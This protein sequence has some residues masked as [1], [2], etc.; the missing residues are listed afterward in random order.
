MAAWLLAM[1]AIACASPAFGA[2]TLAIGYFD[3]TS[4]SADWQPLSKGLADMLITDLAATEG[5]VVVERERLQQV[6]DEIKLGGGKFIDPT[7]A[8]KLGKGLGA[9]H[10]LIGGFLV[11]Q[12]KLR[13]DARMVEVGSGKIGLVA[14]EIGSADDIFAIE[15]K[16][17]EKLRQAL[18]VAKKRGDGSATA[19]KVSADDVKTL[20]QGLDALDAGRIDEARR[21]LGA[22]AARKPDFS[23]VQR[24]LDQLSKKIKQ[25]LAQSKAAPEK[26]VALMS[27][28]EQGKLEAC[29]KL[30]MEVT[31]LLSA[32]VKATMRVQMPDGG[33][34]GE[35]G[36]LLAAFYAVTL[37][38]L[39]QPALQPPVCYGQQPAGTVI[40]M[41]LMSLQQLAQLQ[42]KCDP[43]RLQTDP[44]AER[45]R[46][47]CEKQAKRM[48]DMTDPSGKVVVAARDY[49]L[50][51]VQ[52][53]TIFV[54][55]FAASPYAQ[56]LL[57]QIQEY[58]DHFRIANLS[59]ADKDKALK[60]AR[61]EV[62]RK[63]IAQFTAY[64]DMG[65]AMGMIPASTHMLNSSPGVGT[66][67]TLHLSEGDMTVG[68]GKIELSADGG[69]TWQA[70]PLKEDA[71]G[72]AYTHLKFPVNPGKRLL[73]AK[74]DQL[75]DGEGGAKVPKWD[76]LAKKWV[77]EAVWLEA[78]PWTAERY[79]AV[80]ARLTGEDGS[81]LTICTGKYDD[82]LSKG[83]D[84]K[85]T[86]LFGRIYCKGN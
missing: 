14:Q 74:V 1:A 6:L 10:M 76:L 52:M 77:K 32:T 82:V 50:L 8:Q 7:T 66:F 9:T 39:D 20:G 46:A 22:L 34:A 62:S 2:T 79:A 61:T 80:R 47:I 13:V 24:G 60:V 19:P 51:M 28:I 78:A 70:W 5:L 36:R 69:K 84:G 25:I 55:R 56:S 31:G 45:Q 4:G 44:N 73:V 17:A 30:M 63:A 15:A 75:I 64:A 65:M 33:D 59:A 81:E 3:N 86:W 72:W 38:A 41:F 48:P 26:I 67:F 16:L 29:Q 37:H 57:P 27:E 83:S 18:A 43:L 53:G 12:G 54:D 49:P 58:V 71:P 68:L 23:Q 21:I 85:P 11:S 40:A 35:A 42:L